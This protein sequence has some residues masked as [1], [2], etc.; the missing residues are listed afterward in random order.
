MMESVKAVQG[1]NG[2]VP[3]LKV[4]ESM[5]MNFI[6]LYINEVISV[7]KRSMF[8]TYYC[9]RNTQEINVKLHSG[10]WI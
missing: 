3:A 1:K 6:K 10:W 2:T 4:P 9:Y 8:I 5:K 7:L